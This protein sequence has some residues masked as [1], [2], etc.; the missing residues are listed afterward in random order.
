VK[1]LQ[2]G[3][4]GAEL[5]LGTTV[6]EVLE[7]A[8]RAGPPELADCAARPLCLGCCTRCGRLDMMRAIGER[9][10]RAAIP[11]ERPK[12]DVRREERARPVMMERSSR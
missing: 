2:P 10:R 12:L 7:V 3:T 9:L 5:E 8:Q 1:R 11:L 6:L 4:T